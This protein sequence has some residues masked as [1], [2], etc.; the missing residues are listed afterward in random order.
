VVT[1]GATAQPGGSRPNEK[2]LFLTPQPTD[3]VDTAFVLELASQ[4]RRQLS[5]QMRHKLVVYSDDQICQALEP[6][7]YACDAILSPAESEL[8]AGFMQASAYVIGSLWRESATPW[9]RFRFVDVT[10]NSGIAGWLTVRGTP[11]DQPRSFARTV[12]DSMETTVTAAE[13][14][15]E[16]VD[17]RNRGDFT[18]AMDRA[19]RAFRISPNN[20]AA[21]ICA[22]YASEQLHQPIDSQVQYLRRAVRGDSVNARNWQRLG[23]LLRQAGDTAGAFDAFKHQTLLQSGDRDLRV[24]VVAGAVSLGDF[25]QAVELIDDWITRNPSDT[26]MVDLKLGTCVQGEMWRC[27]LDTHAAIAQGDS[28]LLSDTTFYQQMIGYTQAL[29]DQHA[30]L[31]W[32]EKA[33]QRFPESPSFL[34]ARVAALAGAGM[35]DSLPSYYDHL[36]ALDSTD[37]RAALAGAELL[38]G[39]MTIDTLTPLDTAA[40][41]KG[42]AYLDVVSGA[43]RDTAVLTRAALLYFSRGRELVATRRLVPTAV[44]M[45][46]KAIAD[47]VRGVLRE[48]ANFYLAF[49][50]LLRVYEVDPQVMESKS[51]AMVDQEADL[52]Q[53]GLV[54][55]RIGINVHPSA[56]QFRDNLQ[57]MRDTRIPALK[58]SFSCP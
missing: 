12:V 13:R 35:S 4:V 21:A 10:G 56:Q 29:N 33:T 6:S 54:A 45:L 27:A 40:L 19:E 7:G 3:G 14:A 43:T 31:T 26:A 22:W 46:D 48:Q 42:I 58:Q 53:R 52:I 24:A 5:N 51:C 36:L 32:T 18:D 38:L 25:D 2:L 39:E 37:V 8:L 49:A 47:D 1:S 23:Q 28:A 11:G 15:R 9:A 17:R 50:L 30:Q 20:P 41:M 34:R 57:N 16:C 55:A 44:D